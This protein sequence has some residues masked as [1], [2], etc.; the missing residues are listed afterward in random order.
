MDW[1]RKSILIGLIGIACQVSAAV[2]P[3]NTIHVTWNPHP[4]HC[5]APNV[6]ANCAPVTIKTFYRVVA[7][8]TA[9]DSGAWNQELC[10]S[11][12]GTGCTSTG[13]AANGGQSIQV[14]IQA[15][16]IDPRG[17]SQTEECMPLSEGVEYV[18]PFGPGNPTGLTVTV[19]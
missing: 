6:E 14:K 12:G 18:V 19:E 5:A 11:V 4:N 10:Q 8:G 9:L 16:W 1:I 3:T 15:C 7:R 2:L 17:S 13:I